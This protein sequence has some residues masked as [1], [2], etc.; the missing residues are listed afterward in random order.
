MAVASSLEMRGA[1]GF[2]SDFFPRNALFGMSQARFVFELSS[3][4]L[5]NH[6]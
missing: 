3:K 2:Q 5:F 4:S 1:P 6:A